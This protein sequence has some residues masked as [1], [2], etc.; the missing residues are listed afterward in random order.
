MVGR[1]AP[2]GLKA[3][4]VPYTRGATV[5]DAPFPLQRSGPQLWLGGCDRSLCL[6]G[7]TE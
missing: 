7:L 2:W 4:D 5:A 3:R 1:A 6:E